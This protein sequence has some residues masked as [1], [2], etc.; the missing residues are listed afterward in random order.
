M[1]FHPVEYIQIVEA[2]NSAA[3]ANKAFWPLE[4]S[5]ILYGQGSLPYIDSFTAFI[6]AVGTLRQG[7]LMFVEQH[8]R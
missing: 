6:S 2:L 5:I 1:K 3:H 7:V 4:A 8:N